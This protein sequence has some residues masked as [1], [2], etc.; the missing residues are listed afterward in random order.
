MS[1][2]KATV[3]AAVV[4]LFPDSTSSA[5]NLLVNPDFDGTQA[6]WTIQVYE[7]VTAYGFWTA[8]EG[9]PD[10]GSVGGVAMFPGDRVVIGQ[11]IP[12][13]SGAIDFSVRAKP[14]YNEREAI[15]LQVAVFDVP[16]CSATSIA[17]VYADGYVEVGAGWREYRKTSY[18][19]PDSALSVGIYLMVGN[20]TASNLTYFDH[21]ILAPAGTIVLDRI[22][23]SDF[24]E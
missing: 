1:F 10:G 5:Q 24:E 6:P 11:C 16:N 2:A 7:A 22:F 21:A 14:V 3:F 12:A 13:P 18:M 17:Y 15:S 9:S 4:G 23:Q 19:L 20:A 8:N